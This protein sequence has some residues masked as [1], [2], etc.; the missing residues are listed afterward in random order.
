[1]RYTILALLVLFSVNV[2]A[3]EKSEEKKVRRGL[4]G[5]AK[6][7]HRRDTTVHTVVVRD[8]VFIDRGF[9][10]EPAFMS[11]VNDD[12]PDEFEAR[13]DYLHNLWFLSKALEGDI[14]SDTYFK[15]NPP[16]EF[17]DSVYL[18]RMDDLKSAIPLSYNDIVKRYIE[19]Y[20]KRGRA[21][22]S[23]M[24]GLSKYYF[25]IFEEALDRHGLPLELKYLPVIESALNPTALSK[26]GACGLW[27]FMYA[28]GRMYKLEINSYIDERRDP[29]KSTDAAVSYLKDLYGMYNNWMLVIAAYNC[30]PGNVNKA[31]RRSG[32]YKNYWD[33]YYHLPKETRG[34]IPAFIGAMYA[35]EYHKEHNILPTECDLPLLCDSLEI[36]DLLHFEQIAHKLNIPMEQLRSLNPQYRADAIPG[37]ADKGYILHLPYN[38]VGDFID[39]QDTIFAFN[40]AKYFDLSDRKADPGNRI[41]VHAK[42]IGGGGDRIVYTVKSGDVPGA[43]ASKFKVRLSDLR[44]WNNLNKNLTIRPGQKLVIYANKSV[45]AAHNGSSKTSTAAKSNE[46]IEFE[47]LK[48]GEYVYYTVKSGDNLWQIAKKYPGVSDKDIMRWNGISQ[49]TL[50]DIK[51]G[52]KLKIKKTVG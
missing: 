39:G 31:I 29:L 26:A 12:I 49:N 18:Q 8:T 15:E 44:Y 35:F 16:V 1:M 5:R 27:Q 22:T 38:Y 46:T 47:E 25:P 52:V 4:F 30:G 23:R 32:G 50:R 7:E 24:L 14:I 36:N 3:A 17:A 6:R 2:I 51:P 13:L 41:K 9:D 10:I 40:K 42:P 43:I 20:T 28:T 45:A 33:V 19:L 21:Q 37:S 34:Y 11:D 48:A